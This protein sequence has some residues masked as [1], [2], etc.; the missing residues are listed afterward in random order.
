MKQSSIED[1]S[2]CRKRPGREC[3]PFCYK[4]LMNILQKIFTDHYEE[5]IYLQHP[6]DSDATLPLYPSL[7]YIKSTKE[8]VTLLNAEP[9]SIFSG[10]R[11]TG[12]SSDT[13]QS[14]RRNTT[15]HKA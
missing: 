1:Y 11:D 2:A 4:S 7:P 13:G 5:L 10:R 3:G 8:S 15:P 9:L 12:S 6:R 14:R